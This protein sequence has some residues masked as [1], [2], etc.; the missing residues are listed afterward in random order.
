MSHALAEGPQ[1]SL[2]SIKTDEILRLSA[3]QM[4]QKI[5]L[6]IMTHMMQVKHVNL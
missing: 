2:S 5:F 1:A 4:G 3:I 6:K